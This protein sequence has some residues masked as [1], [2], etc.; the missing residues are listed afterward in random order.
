MTQNNVKA[1]SGQSQ[2]ILSSSRLFCYF[3]KVMFNK[4]SVISLYNFTDSKKS[5]LNF[6]SF[7][8]YQKAA[9]SQQLLW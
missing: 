3:I 8:S 2:G 7:V 6:E 4:R 5:V 1:H 9:I